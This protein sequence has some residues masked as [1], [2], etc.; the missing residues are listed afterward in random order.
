MIKLSEMRNIV[1]TAMTVLLC[2]VMAAG[3]SGNTHSESGGTDSATVLP[4]GISHKEV[5]DLKSDNGLPLL[6][7]FSADWC[8][9]CQMLRPEF[10]KA[11]KALSGKVECRTIDVDEQSALA[12]R[13]RVHSVPTLV[14]L[15][16]DGNEISRAVGYMDS[17]EIVDFTNKAL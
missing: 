12:A 15:S 9:P 10:Q 14:L 2:I 1:G 5:S 11:S 16:P 6:V 4:D 8:Q 17:E 7:D 13:F 3:C